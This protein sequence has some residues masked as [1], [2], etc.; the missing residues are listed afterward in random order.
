VAAINHPLGHARR[1][2]PLP[3]PAF[4]PNWWVLG[5]LALLGVSAMLP[6]LQNSAATSSGFKT[7]ELR[8]EQAKLNGDIRTTEAEVAQL[9]SLTRIERR[10]GEIGLG[11]GTNPIFVNVDQPGPAP[12]KIPSEYLPAPTPST[13][14]PEPWWRSLFSRV[15]LP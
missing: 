10:A 5:A 8:A 3:M 14:E 6:V 1:G 11:P 2:L 9:T 4:K 13:S 15:P 7:Q 12:A